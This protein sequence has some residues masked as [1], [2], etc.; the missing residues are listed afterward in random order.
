MGSR[1]RSKVQRRRRK[2]ASFKF[3]PFLCSCSESSHIILLF[4]T[5]R[6]EHTTRLDD[7]TGL[8]YAAHGLAC[9][10]RRVSPPVP[11]MASLQL[12]DAYQPQARTWHSHKDKGWISGQVTSKQIDGDSVV[13]EFEDDEGKV[14][15]TSPLQRNITAQYYT[16]GKRCTVSRRVQTIASAVSS[17]RQ[18][19]PLE[20]GTRDSCIRMLQRQSEAAHPSSLH[21]MQLPASCSDRLCGRCSSRRCR[22]QARAVTANADTLDPLYTALVTSTP[23]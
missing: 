20:T 11:G 12:L 8:E 17:T 14:S 3:E 19:A 22:D 15:H 6:Y 13:V 18:L 4:R 7:T 10:S 16:A 5:T 9:L 23:Y 1:E 2:R 21:P